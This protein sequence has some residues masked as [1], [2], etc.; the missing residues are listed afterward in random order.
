MCAVVL[1]RHRNSPSSAGIPGAKRAPF[2]GFI[3]PCDPTLRDRA[4]DGSGW[5][6]EIKIDG[7]RAQVQIHHG[8]ITVYSRSGYNW[9]HHFQQ[10]AHAVKALS[11]HDLIIDG[12]ATVFGNTG[13]PDFQ[14][15][16]RELAKKHS[17]RL[18]YLAFDLLYLDGYDLRSAPLIE[19]KRALQHLLAKS[20][21]LVYV[22]YFEMDDGEAVYRHACKLKLEGIVSKRRDSPYRSGRQESWLKLKCTKSDTFPIVAF[23]EKLGARPRRIASLYVGRREGDRLVYA[24]KARSGYTEG[25]AREVRERLDP[26]ISKRSPLSVPVKKPKAT[27]VQ[28]VV[29]AEIE[30]GGITDDGLLREAVFKG[31]RDDLPAVEPPPS[32]PTPAHRGGKGRG[33]VPRETIL[34]LLPDAVAPSKEE[35]AAYWRKMAKRALPFLG[36]R[37]LKLVRHTRGT[38][39]YHKGPLPPVPDAV[40]QLRIEKREGGEGVRVW[41]DSLAGFLGLVKMDV[42]E[43]HP[44]AATVDDIEHADTLVFDLDPGERVP[45]DFVIETAM[46]MRKLLEDEGFNPWPKVTGGKGLHLMA[47][48]PRKLTHDAAHAYARRLAQRLTAIDADRYITSA[49]LA[50]RPGRLFI[51]YLRNGRGTTAVG[52]Y[53]PR[54]REGFPIAA[55][56]TWKQVESGIK[57]DAFT[58]GHPLRPST[59][60]SR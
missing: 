4:P 33:G 16:R 36:G 25:V 23:V 17:D 48:L 37:P 49:S 51:D 39:F 44:W 40:H 53:S 7:Y 20:P 46:R 34:Q 38:I 31:L 3:A 12:E 60:L 14:A 22:E 55:P 5:L 27:W 13:L 10:I 8:R 32:A 26:L 11:G 19:R 29:Q 50:R 35:L 24:G 30:Y 58:M 52:A 6:H 45:W 2:P 59:L 1:R 28:P 47:P 57:P 41:V 15:L 54:V 9:T 18:V 56:V 21:K 42:V 43:V